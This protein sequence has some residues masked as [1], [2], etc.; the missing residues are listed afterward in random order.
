M[1][2]LEIKALNILDGEE[3]AQVEFTARTL[4]DALGERLI[5]AG[6]LTL[7][8]VMLCSLVMLPQVQTVKLTKDDKYSMSNYRF[9]ITYTVDNC[10]PSQTAILLTWSPYEDSSMIDD[11]QRDLR[12][13][14]LLAVL[15]TSTDHKDE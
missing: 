10:T 5:D 14:N 15:G 9:D 8:M 11:I 13:A 4:K 1:K 12:D 6:D 2:S 7:L 3:P